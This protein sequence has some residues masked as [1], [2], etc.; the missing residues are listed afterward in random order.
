MSLVLKLMW[1]ALKGHA[2]LALLGLVLALVASGALYARHWHRSA[3][4]GAKE[5]TRDS[6]GWAARIES[7]SLRVLVT[8]AEGELASARYVSNTAYQR[9]PS[10]KAA[11]LQATEQLEASIRALSAPAKVDSTVVELV[12]KAEAVAASNDTLSGLLSETIAVALQERN[13]ADSLHA[14]DKRALQTQSTITV[15]VRDSLHL[16]QAKT[17]LTWKNGAVIAGGSAAVVLTAK[18]IVRARVKR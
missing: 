9:A 14:L 1:G 13:A 8:I 2:R 7:D 4:E 18:A 6:I 15:G 16:E 3:L 5:A 10:V 17:K 12:A 11:A